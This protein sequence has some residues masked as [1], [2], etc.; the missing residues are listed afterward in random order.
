MNRV[1]ARLKHELGQVLP[2]AIFFFAA[3]QLIAFTRDLML[4]EHGVHI[5]TWVKAAIAALVVGK[6][7]AVSDMLPFLNR[8]PDK[9]LIYNVFWRT[10][11]YFA[12]TLLVRYLELL[13]PLLF[14]LGSLQQANDR[15]F[16]EL[17]WPRFWYVQVW[18]AV[19]FLLYSA[20]REL[21][22][23]LGRDRVLHMFVGWP[24]QSH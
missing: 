10:T 24:K 6:V 18:L 20:I 23:V 14:E 11:I 13:L 4:A 12:A 2:P 7:V 3:F 19:L 22:R 17:I 21:I 9:P 1:A 16:Q 5:S 15:L 8:F